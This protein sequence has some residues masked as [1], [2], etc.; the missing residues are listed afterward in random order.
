MVR[1]CFDTIPPVCYFQNWNKYDPAL[2]DFNVLNY[3]NIL[4]VQSAVCR[5]NSCYKTIW[6]IGIQREN[7]WFV[8]DTLLLMSLFLHRSMLRRIG[9]LAHWLVVQQQ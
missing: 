8:P 3:V 4:G 6:F 9:S 5:A 7:G 2:T 1:I